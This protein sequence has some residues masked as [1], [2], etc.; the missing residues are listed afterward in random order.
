MVKKT[1]TYE[2]ANERL[3]NITKAMA[4]ILIEGTDSTAERVTCISML[5]LSF[6]TTLIKNKVNKTKGEQDE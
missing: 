6:M 4:A 5:Q 2:E 3:E 1:E